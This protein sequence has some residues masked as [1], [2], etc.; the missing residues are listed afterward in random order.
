MPLITPDT[1]AFTARMSEE[2]LRKR[3]ANE[4]LAQLGGLGP[5]GKPLPGVRCKVTRGNGRAGGYTI[6]VTGPMPRRLHL[7]GP[8]GE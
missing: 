2:E 3:M 1:I 4:L 6:D 8:E 5:D 7:A